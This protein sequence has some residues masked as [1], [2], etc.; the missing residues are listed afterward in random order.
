MDEMMLKL[1]DWSWAKRHAIN[2]D[3]AA[4]AER[5]RFGLVIA[6]VGEWLDCHKVQRSEKYGNLLDF[7]GRTHRT[8]FTRKS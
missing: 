2:C 3:L 8:L 4:R 6:G 1:M 7:L 5:L